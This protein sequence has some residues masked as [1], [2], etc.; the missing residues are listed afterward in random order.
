[1]TEYVFRPLRNGKRARLYYGRYALNRGDKPRTVA[2]GTPDVRVARKRLRDII[3]EKQREQEGIIAPRTERDTAALPLTTLLTEFVAD[4]QARKRTP[5]HIRTTRL[6]IEKILNETGWKRLSD[7][8]ADQF[9]KWRSTLKLA[10]KTVREYQASIC[11]FL[12]WLVRLDRIARNPLA[13]VPHVETRGQKVRDTRA[14]TPEELARLFEVSGP[15]SLLYRFLAYTGIRRGEAQALVWGDLHLT[16]E[17]P[18]LLV[19]DETTKDMT[20]RPLPLH[21]RLAALLRA[22][23]PQDAKADAPVFPEFPHFRVLDRDIKAAGIPKRD[24]LNR[25][26]AF[27]SFRKTF[28]T[29]GVRAGIN[30]RAAQEFLGHSDANLTAKIYTDM[31][32]IGLHSEIIKLPW[33]GD[34]V[35]VAAKD[36]L[37]SERTADTSKFLTLCASL[38]EL[39]QNGFLQEIMSVKPKESL[40]E[41]GADG[42]SRTDDQRF[43]IPLLYH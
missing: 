30:Q 41:T 42:R 4:L 18:Y 28:Q 36:T 31:P 25:T 40:C 10:A 13:K 17:Q 14:F 39:S 11:I 19:R 16:G 21:P 43:T 27:H 8:R 34:P 7:I 12:N 5:R 2:L 22:A 24:G 26:V 33:L 20:K 15:R 9:V 38:V 35:D 32:A 37:T 3:V 6:C 29:M 23:A 1:M